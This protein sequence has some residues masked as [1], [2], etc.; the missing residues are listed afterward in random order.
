MKKVLRAQLAFRKHLNQRFSLLLRVA[1][2]SQFS[3]CSMRVY[4]Q[5]VHFENY[6]IYIKAVQIR[7]PI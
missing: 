7:S 4:Y 5:R 6:I 1:V 2:G 3:Y